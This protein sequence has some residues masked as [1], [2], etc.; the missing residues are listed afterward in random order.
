MWIRNLIL[1]TKIDLFS[2][3][4]VW[5]GISEFWWKG[6]G[7]GV[8][9][10]LIIGPH[11]PEN[12]LYELFPTLFSLWGGGGIAYLLPQENH[13]PLFEVVR[14]KHICKF[15]L[16]LIYILLFWWVRIPFG[17]GFRFSFQPLTYFGCAIFCTGICQSPQFFSPI[18]HIDFPA[19]CRLHE[20]EIIF[21]PVEILY[22]HSQWLVLETFLSD[23]Y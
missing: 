19:F 5:S 20:I 6:R 18:I 15:L 14:E 10:I 3:S 22:W 8:H 4:S 12:E 21:Q 23:D 11:R 13:L 17:M 1:A 16:R 7:G 2:S 9:R